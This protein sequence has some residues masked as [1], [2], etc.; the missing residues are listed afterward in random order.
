MWNT[1]G[2]GDHDCIFMGLRE[3]ERY[4]FLL[5]KRCG[6]AYGE[7]EDDDKWN[8]AGL[9]KLYERIWGGWCLSSP[10]LSLSELRGLVEGS[11]FRQIALVVGLLF[12][13]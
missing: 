13:S 11:V 1:R 3:F 8:F 12:E 6:D 5:Q 4:C 9:G 2:L 10:R 7:G